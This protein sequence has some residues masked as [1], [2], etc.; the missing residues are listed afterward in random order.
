MFGIIAA[1]NH[2]ILLLLQFADVF[3]LVP[4]LINY[5]YNEKQAMEMKGVFDRGQPLIQFGAVLGSSFALALVPE[6][7]RKKET[8]EVIKDTLTFSFYLAAGATLGLIIILPEVNLLLFK[9]TNGTFSLQILMLAILLGSIAVTSNAILQ[10]Y[11]YFKQ[12]SQV[13][14]SV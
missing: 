1:L 7:A 14:S 11:G 8:T 13:H 5:G 2:M 9:N 4:E 6:I 12:V 10:S 3:T